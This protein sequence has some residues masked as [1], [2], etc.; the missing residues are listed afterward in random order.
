MSKRQFYMRLCQ[1]NNTD[2]T[3]ILRDGK[4]EVTFESAIYKGFKTLVT[5]IMGN[6]LFC[7]GYNSAEIAFFRRFLENNR[8]NIELESKENA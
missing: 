7:D 6:I 8:K 3:Y 5:D 4:I 1:K 2:V